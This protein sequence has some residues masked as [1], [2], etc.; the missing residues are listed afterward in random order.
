MFKKIR[1][2]FKKGYQSKP[3]TDREQDKIRH[4][5]EKT[6]AEAKERPHVLPQ[7]PLDMTDPETQQWAQAAMTTHKQMTLFVRN[8]Q[9]KVVVGIDLVN[10]DVVEFHHY[11][12]RMLE[13]VQPL[14]QFRV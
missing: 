1:E 13:R 9:T 5:A 7:S 11:T 4:K 8:K 2:G 14:R 3:L 10:G 6:V 12:D